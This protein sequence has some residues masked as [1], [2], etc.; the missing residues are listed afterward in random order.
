MSQTPTDGDYFGGDTVPNGSYP[1]ASSYENDSV[2]QGRRYATPTDP[3]V[4]DETLTYSTPA[5]AYGQP[6][7]DPG[8]ADVAK[9]EA[10]QVK[11]TAAAEG[12][13]VADTAKEEAKNAAGTAVEAGQQVAGTAKVEAKN[14]AAETTAQAKDLAK[15]AVS[16]LS[17]QA[18]AQQQKVATLVHSYA[19]ELGSMA[20]GSQESGQLTDLTHQASAKAGEIGHWLENHEPRDLVRE[21]TSFAR[22]RPGAFLVGAAVAG[23]VV[24]RL[25]RNLAAEAKD[26][27]APSTNGTAHLTTGYAETPTYAATP[28]YAEAPTYTGE[29]AGRYGDLASAD[30]VTSFDT[31]VQAAGYDHR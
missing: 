20:S 10:A 4:A 26:E 9:D 2:E 7:Q 3:F 18:G 11:D 27:A 12:R 17:T 13:Q 22:R 24:G 5:P 14:V 8:T 28:T 30:Q 23:V 19:K 25:T 29:Q 1:P 21:L 15:T 16:E 31:P 6:D